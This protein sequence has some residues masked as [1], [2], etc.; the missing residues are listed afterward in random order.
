MRVL[1]ALL[2]VS[3]AQPEAGDFDQTCEV[4][5][6]CVAVWQDFPCQSSCGGT[7]AAIRADEQERWD[8][9]MKDWERTACV[10]ANQLLMLCLPGEPVVGCPA[11]SCM[12]TE[13]V[14]EL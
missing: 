2:A 3:C 12:I 1:F 7:W 14:S 6:D 13:V 4:A 11:G 10:G 5:E 8:R 9:R